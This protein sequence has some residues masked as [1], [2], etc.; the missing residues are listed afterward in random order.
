MLRA[1]SIRAS[2]CAL[3][4]PE[5]GDVRLMSA[6]GLGC[7]KT[8]RRCNGVEWAFHQMSFRAVET[9]RA[10]PVA[11][12]FGR[13]FSSSFDFLSFHTARVIRAILKVCPRLPVFPRERTSSGPVG[14]S[15]KC[16]TRKSLGSS[17]VIHDVGASLQSHI[18]RLQTLKSPPYSD[19]DLICRKS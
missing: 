14:M 9:S 3:R 1:Q 19:P 16:Q 8:Q 17:N 4:P 13:L 12:S 6:Q 10:C 5:V 2:V 15:Q 7:V 11:S 18:G